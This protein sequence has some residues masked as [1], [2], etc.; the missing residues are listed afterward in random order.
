[1]IFW[2]RDD[3]G[4][5]EGETKVAVSVGTFDRDVLVGAHGRLVTESGCHLF[6]GDEVPGVT[7]HLA[8]ERWREDCEGEGAELLK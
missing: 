1:M 6:C 7:D 2:R 3:A 8:G 4:G 5:G